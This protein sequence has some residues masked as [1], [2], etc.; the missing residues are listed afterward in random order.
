MALSKPHKPIYFVCQTFYPP[1]YIYISYFYKYISIYSQTK[2]RSGYFFFYPLP[3]ILT[4][5]SIYTILYILAPTA[6]FTFP[7]ITTMECPLSERTS[8]GRNT[9]PECKSLK[10]VIYI[11]ILSDDLF[12]PSE[13][14]PLHLIFPSGPWP[15]PL[16]LFTF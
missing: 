3:K 14:S 6:L 9:L 2:R 5:P 4:K 16:L 8:G 15:S 12:L 1:L 10:Y 13:Y 7:C 11:D